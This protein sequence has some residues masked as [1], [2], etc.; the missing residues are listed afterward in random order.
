MSQPLHLKYR[1][2]TLA[3]LVGQPTLQACLTQAIQRHQIAPAY[4]FCG[5]R[6]TGKTS[7]A[8][9]LAKA[10]NCLSYDGPTAIPCGTCSTCK[11]IVNGSALDVTEIDAASH[12]G[13]EDARELVKTCQLAAAQCRYRV[14][15]IDEAH[16][17]TAQAQNALLKLIEEPP[18]RVVFV[19]A[20]TEPHKVLPTISSR[21]LSFE[22]RPIAQNVI[23]RYLAGIVAAEEIQVGDSAITAIARLCKGGLRDALQLVAKAALLDS[24]SQVTAQDIYRMVGQVGPGELKA[25]VTAAQTRNVVDLMQGS[26]ELIE[27]G[28]TPESLHLAL[29]EVY[30]DLLL[31]IEAPGQNHLLTSLLTK[32]QLQPLAQ[33]TTIGHIYQALDILDGAERQLR[34]SPTP[35]P[36]LEATLLKLM[37]QPAQSSRQPVRPTPDAELSLAQAWNRV[38]DT[39]QPKAKALLQDYCQL[40]HIDLARGVATLVVDSA[41]EATLTKHKDKVQGILETAMGQSMKLTLVFTELDPDHDVE[42]AVA[43]G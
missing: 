17:L 5:P 27:T 14:I 24:E 26:R 33:N 10:L 36:W 30:H 13:V 34:F 41:K 31:L 40:S 6:G 42:L 8:R 38:L 35:Q 22:F 25:L 29:L 16:M 21:C 1:P 11:G 32:Q 28:H 7:T 3:D 15:I 18:A 19:L 43:T 37:P 20:T 4:L 9:I 2:Q 39:A 23:K 12:G